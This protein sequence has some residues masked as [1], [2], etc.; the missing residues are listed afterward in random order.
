MVKVLLC[1]KYE[2]RMASNGL[3]AINEMEKGFIPDVI[4]TDVVMPV[5]DGFRFL[6]VLKN[7]KR[8][9]YIPVIWLTC[10]DQS[11]VRNYESKRLVRRVI[12]KPF[13]AEKLLKELIPA[14]ED[15]HGIASIN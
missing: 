9:K 8:F 15:T 5:L 4:V 3:E 2:V 6:T 10:L 13:E 1:E 14:I 7:H 12:I 11:N